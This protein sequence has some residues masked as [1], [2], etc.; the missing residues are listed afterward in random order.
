MASTHLSVRVFRRLYD[1]LLGLSDSL[2][3]FRVRK[4]F[5]ILEIGHDG[6]EWEANAGRT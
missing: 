1:D 6:R 2:G 5:R 4:G 3:V